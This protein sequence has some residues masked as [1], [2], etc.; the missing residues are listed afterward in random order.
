[1]RAVPATSYPGLGLGLYLARQIAEAHGG[2]IEVQS[3][4]DSG[5]IFTVSLPSA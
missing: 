2:R 3:G 1:E 4:V 5:T